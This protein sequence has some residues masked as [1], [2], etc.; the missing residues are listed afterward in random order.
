MGQMA[1]D[2]NIRL[3]G[4]H[5]RAAPREPADFVAYRVFN[6]KRDEIETGKRTLRCRHVDPD[7]AN[8]IKPI[9]PWQRV[10]SAIYIVFVAVTIGR[11]LPQNA[12]GDAAFE[13]DPVTEK[14]IT[15]KL[16]SAADG[17]NLFRFELP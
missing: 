11:Y 10:N 8:R 15:A 5:A 17:V 4:I 16:D 7:G 1:L 6:F 13:I 12:A 2:R 9:S 14:E 3:M